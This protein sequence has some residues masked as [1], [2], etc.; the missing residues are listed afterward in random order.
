MNHAYLKKTFRLALAVCLLAGTPALAAETNSVARPGGYQFDGTISR[1]VLENY[2][3]RSI[4][5]EGLLNGRGDLNDNIRMLKSIGAKYV[6]RALC[7]WIQEKS[8]RAGLK[9]L[10]HAAMAIPFYLRTVFSHPNA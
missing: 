7:L 5:M 10:K 9:I 6:G 8:L 2:L 1:V 4:T 3:A